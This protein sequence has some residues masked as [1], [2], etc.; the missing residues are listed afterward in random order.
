MAGFHNGRHRISEKI[1]KNYIHLP[2]VI[3]VAISL[4]LAR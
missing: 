1:N 3:S 2:D 4:G